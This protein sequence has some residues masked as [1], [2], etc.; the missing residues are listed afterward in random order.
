MSLGN[1]AEG[2]VSALQLLLVSGH[3]ARAC[4]EFL[5]ILEQLRDP[6]KSYCNPVIKEDRP[7]LSCC[8][9]SDGTAGQAAPDKGA[10]DCQ[11]HQTSALG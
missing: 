9:I 6:I 3:E 2:I 8:G 7:E 4:Q 11:L 5:D 1:E 10:E